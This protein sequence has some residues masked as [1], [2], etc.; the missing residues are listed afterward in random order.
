MDNQK[1]DEIEFV[2]FD[3]ET[4]GFE[5]EAGDRIIEIAAVKLIGTQIKNEFHALINP[6]RQISEE[7]IAIH[8]ITNAMLKDAP[9]MEEVMPKFLDFVEGSVLCA[10]NA[11]FDLGFI[12]KELQLLNRNLAWQIPVI[13]ILAMARRLLPHL[14]QYNL[15]Y[16][17]NTLGVKKEQIHRALSDVYL[18]VDVFK[19]LKELL[20]AKG[21]DDFRS[22]QTLFGLASPYLNDLRNQKISRIQEALDL[23]VRLKIKYLSRSNAEVTEREVIPRQIK[24]ENNKYYLVGYCDLRKEERTFSIDGILHLEIL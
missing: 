13:D 10:Y 22:L 3:T 4:T 15:G 24:Q 1:I 6:C 23:K 9:L 14:G 12:N 5:P 18:S 2:I 19:W 21:I 16:V 11:A 17:A 20:K 8:H 7:A